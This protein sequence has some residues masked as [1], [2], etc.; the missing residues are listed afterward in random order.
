MLAHLPTTVLAVADDADVTRAWGVAIVAVAVAVGVGLLILWIAAL[1]GILG[2]P[3]YSSS[4]KALWI[5]V[6]IALPFLGALAWF[7][8]GRHTAL[9]AT[10]QAVGAGQVRR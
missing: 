2:S 7:V 1:F 8:W 10:V 9:S 6:V 4:G 3:L 5:L